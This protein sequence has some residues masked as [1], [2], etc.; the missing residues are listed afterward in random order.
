MK[1]IRNVE[2]EEINEPYTNENIWLIK[3]E[4]TTKLFTT[5]VK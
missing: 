5:V 4:W 3:K 2:N 1:D